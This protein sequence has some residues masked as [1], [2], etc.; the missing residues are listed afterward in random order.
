MTD[1]A[2]N[3]RERGVERPLG[4]FGMRE[5]VAKLQAESMPSSQP[6]NVFEAFE[7]KQLDP[8]APGVAPAATA[9]PAAAPAEA[10][11]KSQPKKQAQPKAVP[12]KAA[13]KAG[14]NRQ[15]SL[16]MRKQLDLT[17]DDDVEHFLESHPY[18]KGFLP[19]KADVELYNQ[20]SESHMP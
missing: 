14:F 1:L 3:V 18:V 16:Q 13:P 15:N 17:V 9:P 8:V 4:A 6:L 5:F 11:P 12:A 10:A 2:V 20:L 19:T 7:G